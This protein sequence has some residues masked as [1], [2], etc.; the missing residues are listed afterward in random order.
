MVERAV[1]TISFDVDSEAVDDTAPDIL[2]N[3]QGDLAHLE[4]V[5]ITVHIRDAAD[6][7]LKAS[8]ERV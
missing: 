8:G 3:I 5:L 2:R 6:R 4:D 7:V 1:L